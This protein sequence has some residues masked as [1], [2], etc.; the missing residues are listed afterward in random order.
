MVADFCEG[1]DIGEGFLVVV[2]FERE[3]VEE[4]LLGVVL[5]APICVDTHG[6]V[7]VVYA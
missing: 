7:Y 4:P 1:K 5:F 2:Y 3:E 6:V